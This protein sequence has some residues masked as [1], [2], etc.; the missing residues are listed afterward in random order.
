MINDIDDSLDKMS[1][2]EESILNSPVILFP[3]KV[4]QNPPKMSLG[5]KQPK[6]N[7][8]KEVPK[9]N[10]E[11]LNEKYDLPANNMKGVYKYQEKEVSKP[12]II[13]NHTK[14]EVLKSNNYDMLKVEV[15]KSRHAIK[16]YVKQT[17]ANKEYYLKLVNQISNLKDNINKTDKKITNIEREYRDIGGIK[18]EFVSSISMSELNVIIMVNL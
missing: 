10:F 11:K 16:E 5:S 4:K 8:G 17:K 18:P 2:F 15:K 14:N 6:N 12:L 9:L 3:K 13:D 7:S 1:D